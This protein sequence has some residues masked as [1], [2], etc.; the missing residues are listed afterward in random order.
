MAKIKLVDTGFQM[1][2][3]GTYIFKV[4]KV[5]YDEDFGDMKLELITKNGL[6]HTERFGLQDKNGEVNEGAMKAFSYTA[7]VLLNNPNLDMIDE[8]DLVGCYMK[9]TVAHKE[10]AT[11]ST[12]TGKP[13]VN[14]VLDDKQA[15]WG[16][17]ADNAQAATTE[18]N[19]S[20]DDLDDLV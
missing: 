17:D 2:P 13:F 15:A 10:S 8:Q 19:I 11:V 16:F 3:E 12:K 7:R 5:T 14:A 1:I 6:K 20:L 9:A 4:N 18:E